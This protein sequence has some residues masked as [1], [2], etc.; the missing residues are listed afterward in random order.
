[1][2]ESNDEE[3][4]KFT[5]GPDSE[6]KEKKTQILERRKKRKGPI[7]REGKNYIL[8]KRGR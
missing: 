5:L 1:L 3:N 6:K 2:G 7:L 8:R 4:W